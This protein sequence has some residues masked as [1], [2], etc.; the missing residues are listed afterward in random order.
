MGKECVRSGDVYMRL[1][2]HGLSTDISAAVN[3]YLNA[4]AL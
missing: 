3:V 4:E 1:D 2:R